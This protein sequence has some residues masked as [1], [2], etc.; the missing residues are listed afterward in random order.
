MKI[1]VIAMLIFIG[2][3]FSTCTYELSTPD[4]CFQENVLPVFISNCTMANCHNSANGEEYDLTT[5]EGIMKG[6]TP[7]HPYQSEIYNEIRG[8]HPSMPPV[9]KLSAKDVNYIKVWI[10]MGAE[11]SSD[12][13]ICDSS[14]YSYSG[15]IQPLLATWCLGCHSGAAAGGGY[16]FS[17]YTG[18]LPAVSNTKLLG[19]LQ[20]LSGYKPMPQNSQLSSCD[21]NAIEKWVNAGTPNN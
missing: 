2:L 4:V 9:N 11:N 21:L 16:N 19:S 1:Y 18:V 10:K 8:N 6:I 20:H 14:N 5:Y 12:C 13:S 3:S 15:R 7:K 17:T